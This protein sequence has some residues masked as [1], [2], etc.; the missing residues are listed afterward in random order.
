MKKEVR[1]QVIRTVL[2]FVALAIVD[3]V[4][5]IVAHSTAI[6]YHELRR[7]VLVATGSAVFGAGLTFFLIRMFQL[8]EHP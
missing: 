4:L 1:T 3:A 5:L 6:Y 7:D 2:V 8:T